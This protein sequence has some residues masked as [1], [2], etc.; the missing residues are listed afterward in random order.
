MALVQHRHGAEELVKDHWNGLRD[1]PLSAACGQ[2][3]WVVPTNRVPSML[4]TAMGKKEGYHKKSK[5]F[6]V[7][8]MRRVVGVLSQS[9]VASFLAVLWVWIYVN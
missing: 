2:Q 6:S 9:P 5:S 4:G 8:F 7:G 1:V 3:H